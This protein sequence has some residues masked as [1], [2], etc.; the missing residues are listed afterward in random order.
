MQTQPLRLFADRTTILGQRTR[1]GQSEAGRFAF[2]LVELLVVIAIIGILVAL[3]LPAIQAAREAARRTQCRNNL[4]NIGLSIHN[5]YGTYKF[6]PTGGT[7]NFASIEDYLRDTY[8]QT[9]VF[10]RVGP[11]NGPLEQGLGWLYQILPYL[12][13]GAVADLYRTQQIEK[14]GIALYNCPSR[15]GIT[16]SQ[17]KS[18]RSLVDYAATVAGPTRTEIGDAEFN[19][20]LNDPGPT[21]PYFVS[22]Q[23]DFW[24]CLSCSPN[25]A[26]G[27]AQLRTAYVGGK[28][29]VFR[30]IIQ[31]GDWQH[32]AP[33]VTPPGGKHVGYM[34]KMTFAKITD[35]T[36]KTLLAADKWVPTVWHD[37]SGGVM[38]D[39]GWSDGWDFDCLRYTL[40]A[41]HIDS[42]GEPPTGS[43]ASIVAQPYWLGSSHPG[44]FNALFGDGSVT[45][46]GYD[47][48]V[49]TLNR[50]G[51]RS[52]GEP[53]SQDY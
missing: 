6:F 32:H 14:T 49:E 35:G 9:S 46:L 3:L 23:E 41:P 25:S 51:N 17:G 21:Y 30:G 45:G 15:R 43:N 7:E 38:D 1:R 37:G 52:D 19:K 18:P 12:E 39:R 2:T 10:K 22:K 44:G 20:Y 13:E 33:G 24:G 40:V 42:D 36:S 48:D 4:K 31:R 16:F 11:P 27:I 28:P 53:I 34:K 47:I 50:L 8:S 26:R 5:F 29:V